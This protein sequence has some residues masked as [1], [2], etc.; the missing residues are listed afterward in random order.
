MEAIRERLAQLE[1]LIGRIPEDEEQRSINDRLREAIESDQ[2]AESLYISLVAETSERLEAAEE[3][4][5]ILKKAVANTSVGTGMFKPKIPEPKAFGGARSSKELENFLWDMEHYFSAAKVGLDE[6][7][8]IAVMYLTGDAKLWWRTRSKEDLNAGRPKVETWETLKRELKEQFLPN[9]TSWIARED[10]K[11]LRQDGSVRDYVKK[12]SSLILD[13]DNMF[14]EDITFNFLSGLQPW[15]QL[16]LRRQKVSDLS[17]AIAAADG[18]ADFRAGASEGTAGASSVSYPLM[19][20]YE[21]KRRKKGLVGENLNKLMAMG[22]QKPRAR[23]RFRDQV[24]VVLFTRVSTLQ[25]TA[26]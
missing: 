23:K 9:N 4:I 22:S 16:E 8:N 20:R 2:W 18:L 19:D 26:R 6:Q 24:R 14:E 17:S 12:F 7:V 5:I 3:A 15:A 1:E 10:L 13:I 25:E 21:M 11:K